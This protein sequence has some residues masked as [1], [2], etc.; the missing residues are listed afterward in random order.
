MKAKANP[1]YGYLYIDK[2]P[3]SFFLSSRNIILLPAES[4]ENT[5]RAMVEKAN[6][7][8]A[9]LPEF[10]FGHTNSR[11]IA[12]MRTS[13]YRANEFGFAPGLRFTTPMIIEASGNTDVFFGS[14][15]E[16]WDKFH[17]ITFKGGN[18]NAIFPPYQALEKTGSGESTKDGVMGIRTLPWKNYTI[19]GQ[20]TIDDQIVKYTISIAQAGLSSCKDD[21]T[22]TLGELNSF[23]RFSFSEGKDFSQIERYYLIAKMFVSLLTMQNNIDFETYLSQRK[24]NGQFYRTATCE[25]YDVYENYADRNQCRVIQIG[26][27]QD[28][29]PKILEAIATGEYNT[30]CTLLP[31]DNRR[32]GLISIT[33]V[34]DLCTALEVAYDWDKKNRNKDKPIKSLCKKAARIAIKELQSEFPDID[35][36]T[37]TTI[38]KT[39]EYLDYNAK[40]KIYTLYE[41]NQTA[42]D[43]VAK[44]HNWPPLTKERIEKFTSLRNH[45]TH[46]GTFD[47]SNIDEIYPLLYALEYTCALK[48]AG[49]QE[50]TIS[51]LIWKLF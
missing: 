23:I 3:Y 21:N 7:R 51:E 12:I 1:L 14:L 6:L 44:K 16:D 19:K 37:E 39:F 27:I 42:V 35:L 29:L 47:W 24:A 32:L 40:S 11:T 48:H 26:R 15:P 2:D 28:Q 30:L 36:G 43:L 10:L 5:K 34:Q 18:I 50:K 49:I 9:D 41:E 38:K 25:I 20:A 22:Y 17:A 31:D 45:K 8:K 46:D 33:N 4:S 13:D